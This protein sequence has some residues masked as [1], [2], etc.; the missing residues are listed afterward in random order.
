[1]RWRAFRWPDKPCWASAIVCCCWCAA[2]TALSNVDPDC[3]PEPLSFDPDRFAP[4]R[5]EDSKHPFAYLPFGGGRHRCLG[6]SFAL[7]QQK[8]IFSVLLRRFEFELVDPA[9][10]YVDNYSAMVVRPRQPFRV[11]Y[12]RRPRVA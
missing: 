5:E 10:S 1:M 6:A 2:T 7:I 9:A 11:R 8:A 4:P 12:Q 3:F